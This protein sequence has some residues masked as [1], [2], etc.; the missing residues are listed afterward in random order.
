VNDDPSVTL[1]QD[2]VTTTAGTVFALD[3]FATFSAGGG[4]DEATQTAQ[5]YSVTATNGALFAVAPMID[6]NGRLTFTASGTTGTTT[7]TVTV[8]DSEGATSAEVQFSVTVETAPVA[9]S[10]EVSV[11]VAVDPTARFI[12]AGADAGSAGTVALFDARTGTPLISFQPFGN[13]GGGVAVALGDLTG[14]G[15]AELIVATR[16]SIGLLAVYD[17]ATGA[18]LVPPVRPFANLNTGLQITTADVDG[19]GTHD[20]VF[21]PERGAPTV[22]AFSFTKGQFVAVVDPLPGANLNFQLAAGNVTGDGRAEVILS[23]N[24]FVA[25]L[26][27][28]GAV[29]ST[30][31]VAPGF[32]GE[33]AIAVGDTNGDGT[34]EIVVAL[35]APGADTAVAAFTGQGALVWN[36]F[37]DTGAAMRR[38]GTNRPA[39][40]TAPRLAVADVTGDQ[41]ADIL[42]G[43]QPGFGTSRVTVFDGATRQQVRSDLAFTD[44]LGLFTDAG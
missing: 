37:A 6:T 24:G 33:M 17:L 27:P 1:L 34:R 23:A 36:L 5:S 35:Q 40:Q 38:D 3:G 14:D 18:T 39:I 42:L 12:A 4:T 29:L 11:N 9:P 43:S 13:Y 30:F 31:A 22:A 2:S 21:S 44:T 16:G 28:S 19:D 7:V 41:I 26:D 25:V 32:A 20:L 15:I 8:T 10:P